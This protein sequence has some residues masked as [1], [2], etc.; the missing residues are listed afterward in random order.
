MQN[1]LTQQR[2]RDLFR[3]NKV[4]RRENEALRREN[5]EANQ[6]AQHFWET[7]DDLTQWG[8]MEGQFREWQ[9]RQIRKAEPKDTWSDRSQHFWETYADQRRWGCVN[10]KYRKWQAQQL[11]AWKKR[12]G[13]DKE[14][15]YTAW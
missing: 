12:Q 2:C 13:E 7:Y 3:E 10:E 9:A 5:K 15:P 1:D 11:C 14:E 8:C 4:L 6:T